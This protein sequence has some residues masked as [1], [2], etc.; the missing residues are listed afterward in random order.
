MK[1]NRIKEVLKEKDRSQRWLARKIDLSANAVNVIC[2]N[3]T[4]PRIETLFSIANALEVDVC[5]L[6]E[7][8]AN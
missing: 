2:Q 1:Y 6:L 4:Q 3:K 7:R 8:E 5:D